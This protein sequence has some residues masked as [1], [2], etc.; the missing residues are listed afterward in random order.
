MTLI[1]RKFPWVFSLLWLVILLVMVSAGFWQLNRAKEKQQIN[2][3]LLA[4]EVNRPQTLQDWQL[5]TAFDQVEVRG[6]YVNTHFL[7]DNQIMDGQVGF[8]IFTAFL[9]VDDVLL[10]INRGWSADDQQNF[11]LAPNSQTVSALLAD[12]PRPGIQLGEQTINNQAVQHLTY[13]QQQPTI[14]L[15]KQRH[16]QQ[17]STENCIILPRVVKLD[18]AMSHGFKRHWQLPRMTVAKHRAYA[19][20][21]FTMSLVLCVIYV[22][23]INKTYASKN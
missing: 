20:Q 4:G 9:T 10:L 15:L 21:W 3:R 8:F 23:F 13:L 19:I 16:C 5:L 17:S 1:T 18:K 6:H 22:I 7:L 2:N 11:D 14:D 12:W